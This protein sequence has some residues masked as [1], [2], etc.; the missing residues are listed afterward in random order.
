LSFDDI[1]KFSIIFSCAKLMFRPA[2]KI[3]I[4][5]IRGRMD[6]GKKKRVRTRADD[7]SFD[8]NAVQSVCASIHARNGCDAAASHHFHGAGQE[9]PPHSDQDVSESDQ[10]E[11]SDEPYISDVDEDI[12]AELLAL[13]ADEGGNGKQEAHEADPEDASAA[14]SDVYASTDRFFSLRN[15]RRDIDNT[16]VLDLCPASVVRGSSPKQFGQMILHDK[17]GLTEHEIEDIGHW[18]RVPGFTTD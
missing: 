11:S 6:Q 3:Q 13:E 1:I 14:T 8:L 10:K 18:L 15:P 5:I 12:L 4:L 9:S 2:Y 7:P 16:D 17:H